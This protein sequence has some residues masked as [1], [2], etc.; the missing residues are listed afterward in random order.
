MQCWLTKLLE[1]NLRCSN[2]QATTATINTLWFNPLNPIV[3]FWL[4]HT[5]HCAEKIVSERLRAGSVSAERVGQGE[6]G[7]VTGRVLCTWWLLGLALKRPWLVPGG[8][9]H[10]LTTW[11]GLE[12]ITLTLQRAGFLQERLLGL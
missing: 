6:V 12:N 2:G 3:H 8:S 1:L 9:P 4:H 10:A 11:T 7:G 5:A